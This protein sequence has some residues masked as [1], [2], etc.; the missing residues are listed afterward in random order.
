MT[1]FRG[2]LIWSIFHMAKAKILSRNFVVKL[3]SGTEPDAHKVKCKKG[4]D[5]ARRL[6]HSRAACQ[7]FVAAHSGVGLRF[8]P[9]NPLAVRKFAEVL[10]AKPGPLK[11]ARWRNDWSHHGRRLISSSPPTSSARLRSRRHQFSLEKTQGCASQTSSL[12]S[13]YPFSKLF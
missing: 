5:N 8:S 1:N 13:Q 2:V 12:A 11:S 10:S 6:F 7:Q 3:F 9:D 4:S